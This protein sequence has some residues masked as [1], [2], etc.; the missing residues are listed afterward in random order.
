MF[1]MGRCVMNVLEFNVMENL[2]LFSVAVLRVYNIT[3][4][5]AGP[6]FIL[7]Q[8]DRTTDHF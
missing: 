7:C 8:G 5:I 1:W 3:V 4:S 6:L 2:H